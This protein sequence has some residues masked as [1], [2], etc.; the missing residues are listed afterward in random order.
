MEPDLEHYREKFMEAVQAL[1]LVNQS[2]DNSIAKLLFSVARER[3]HS[4][5][6]KYFRDEND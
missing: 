2:D 1:E 4:F 5:E 3:L 6:F